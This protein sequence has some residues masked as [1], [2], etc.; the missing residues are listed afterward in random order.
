MKQNG[1]N[2]FLL[3]S[4]LAAVVLAAFA[5]SVP[6]GQM[7]LAKS[8][9]TGTG[10][11]GGTAQRQQDT[12]QHPVYHSLAAKSVAARTNDPNALQAFI[13]EIFRVTGVDD[14]APSL[15]LR[16][17]RAET[18][19]RMTGNGSIPLGRLISSLNSITRKLKLPAFF[20]TTAEQV[21]IHREFVKAYVS[22]GLWDE[23]LQQ[24]F[25]SPSQAT[26]I[27]LYLAQQKRLN[28]TY[29]VEPELWSKRQRRLMRDKPNPA[30]LRARLSTKKLASYSYQYDYLSAQL[31]DEVSPIT[32][33]M[34]ELLDAWGISR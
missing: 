15:R 33:A 21:E 4:G 22:T 5:S 31:Q 7:L 18:A 25:I 29:Q 32:V 17:S 8:R 20:L 9:W 14:A 19:Y 23:D 34:H 16:V 11:V 28:T 27:A 6:A 1:K 24:P 30:L 12:L 2:A 26:F 10:A 3:S 13:D